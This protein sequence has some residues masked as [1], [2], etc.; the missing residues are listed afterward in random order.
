MGELGR[1]IILS[2]GENNPNLKSDWRLYD[3]PTIVWIAEELERR[4]KAALEKSDSPALKDAHNETRTR[5]IDILDECD[6]TVYAQQKWKVAHAGLQGWL[7]KIEAE[8]PELCDSAATEKQ[9]RGTD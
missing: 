9:E 6:R 4:S 3:E 5:I 8:N 7:F 1:L 2:S